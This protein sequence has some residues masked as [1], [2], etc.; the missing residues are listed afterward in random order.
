[1][2]R[3]IVPMS[4]VAAVLGSTVINDQCTI[5]ETSAVSCRCTGSEEFEIPGDFRGYQNTSSLHVQYCRSAHLHDMNLILASHIT[6]IVVDNIDGILRFELIPKSK[7]LKDL[8]LSHIRWIPTLTRQIFIYTKEI[9][10]LTIEN[11]RIGHLGD[12]FSNTLITNVFLTNVTVEYAEKLYFSEERGNVL[13][14]ADSEFQNIANT[15]N[16]ANFSNVEIVRSRFYLNN[17][18]NLKIEADEVLVK[19][20]VFSNTSIS[21][22][23]QN[24]VSTEDICATGKSSM[25]LYSNK[26]VSTNNRLPNQINYHQKINLKPD[27]RNNTICIAGNCKCSETSG[28][29]TYASTI[30]SSFAYRFL[31]SVVVL[32]SARVKSF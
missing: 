12:L 30:A 20:S 25:S 10:S 2:K 28:Q 17:P 4:F 21:I 19:D 22:I 26:I 7:K 15:W 24:S 27:D 29:D 3:M 9:N 8:R 1:M 5:D 6:E 13:R 14:I 11:A 23:A 16:F 18:G 31:M 32:T